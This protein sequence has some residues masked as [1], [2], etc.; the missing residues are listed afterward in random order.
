MRSPH[1]GAGN[2]QLVPG[3]VRTYVLPGTAVP[4]GRGLL[5]SLP[6][7]SELLAGAVPAK[8]SSCSPSAGKPTAQAAGLS[9]F[10]LSCSAARLEPSLSSISCNPHGPPEGSP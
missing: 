4:Q 8:D 1:A 7:P 3:T 5:A 10:S 9:S 6:G 2:A